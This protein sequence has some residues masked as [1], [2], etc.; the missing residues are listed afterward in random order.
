MIT[1][2]STVILEMSV[3]RYWINHGCVTKWLKLSL[4]EHKSYGFKSD[5]GPFVRKV[6]SLCYWPGETILVCGTLEST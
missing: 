3:E 4:S 2:F 1:N 5:H 6:N